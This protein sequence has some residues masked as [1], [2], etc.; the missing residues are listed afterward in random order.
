[1]SLSATL[2]ALAVGAI[3]SL[4]AACG[5][6]NDNN[7]G[8]NTPTT[9]A[10]Q[11]PASDITVGPLVSGTSA[12]IDG[13]R[14][15]TDFVYDDRGPNTDAGDMTD[16]HSAG[17]DAAYPA[18]LSNA[19]DFVQVQMRRGDAGLHVRVVLE[20]LL[21]P[22]IPL[23]GIAFDT[24]SNS[25][26]GAARLPGTWQ[27][28]GALGI[29]LLVVLEQ[30]VGQVLK[31]ENS[32]WQPVAA[33]DVAVHPDDNT[34]EATLPPA[35]VAPGDATWN[36]IGVAGTTTASWFTGAGVIHDLAF[37]TD[38]PLYQWQEYRQSDILAGKAPVGAAFTSIDFGAL[39]AGENALPDALAP[40]F[41]TYLY[42]S[43][44]KLPEGVVETANGAEFHGP[45]QP[46][47]VY[48][49]DEGHREGTAM[50]VFLHGLTQN[51]LGSVIIG[52]IY[53][54]TGRVL[55]EEIGELTPYTRDGTNFPPHN[56]TVWPL[57]RG[58]GLYYEGIAEQDVLDVL[59]DASLRFR[60][61]PDRIILSGASMGGIGAFR[62]GALYPDLWSVAVP[63]IGLAR[64]SVEPL[65]S[66]FEN[67]QILQINGALDT[68]IPIERAQHTTDVLDSL[69]L[70]FRAWMLDQRNHEAGGYAYDCVYRDLPDYVRVTAPARVRYT[71]DP[72]MTIID[73]ASGLA[74]VHDRAY[75]VSG[76]EVADSSAPGSVDAHSLALPQRK[77]DQVR[78]TDERYEG[79]EPVSDLCGPNP[80][81]TT[82]DTW[83]YRAVEWLFGAELPI[84]RTLA[85]T[86]TN[87]A[88]A[89]FD[90]ARAGLAGGAASTVRITSD[91]SSAVM[92]TG[93]NAGQVITISGATVTADA[94]GAATILVP[95][96]T[97]TIT[98]A[99]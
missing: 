30:G 71:V 5:S 19:A 87:L 21:D 70:R 76:I 67:L 10:L 6:S 53:L 41:H 74:L 58:A 51:H 46:Y 98:I 99:N 94:S 73:S 17:G 64:A 36:A 50:T 33:F 88:A 82:G 42:R 89:R 78:H 12:L 90:L 35:E 77:V 62:I 32:D 34:L 18:G 8:S 72:A 22:K 20:T 9:P 7:S 59:A 56:L 93:L 69:G 40:G 60:P 75:W 4:G 26:T 1:M 13:G 81:I 84:E 63:V 85:A 54:G 79:G 66:N 68:L 55:S 38:E 57:A 95:V 48:V 24:D 80:D 29:E 28:D 49:P 83:R 25:T 27:P 37:V 16:I 52:D 14:A 65:L 43:A 39:K 11:W 2:R 45:Y 31:W 86:L 3:L 23:V 47:L 97:S 91:T 92:L 15:W 61:D 44:L 96:G